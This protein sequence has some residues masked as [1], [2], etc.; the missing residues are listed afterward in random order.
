LD[1]EHFLL[2]DATGLEML[3]QA[4]KEV[5]GVRR[6][7]FAFCCLRTHPR[8]IRLITSS[9][10]QGN[11]PFPIECFFGK[12]KNLKGQLSALYQIVNAPQELL[13]INDCA[14][15]KI[16]TVDDIANANANI[17]NSATQLAASQINSYDLIESVIGFVD[18]EVHEDAKVFLDILINRSPE[19][20]FLGLVEI[21]VSNGLNVR[22]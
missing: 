20:V 11:E 5:T 2:Y 22:L 12:W 1:Y 16:I 9:S 21:E 3:V 13:N 8:E 14:T 10:L 19:L 7:R 6:F 17:R 18:T 15:K 4:W